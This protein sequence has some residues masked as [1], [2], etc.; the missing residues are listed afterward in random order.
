[1]VEASLYEHLFPLTT[2]M[3]QRVVEH[4]DGDIL[5]ADRWTLSQISG[6]GGTVAMN[7]AV[8]GGVRV[9]SGATNG[10]SSEIDFCNIRQYCDCASVFITVFKL[11]GTVSQQLQGG[12]F[13]DVAGGTSFSIV[14]TD[15]F[16]DACCFNMF[17]F[18]GTC[19]S[20]QSSCVAL[21]TSAHSHKVALNMCNNEWTIDGGC[22]CVTKTTNLPTT[23]LQPG[24][25]TRARSAGAKSIDLIYYE[26][27]NT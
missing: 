16:N 9:S 13:G 27:Y 21:D 25:F 23:K 12:L 8:N 4:F 11:V 10:N 15:T 19:S 18:D 2:V 6:C 14:G 1:M 5:C 17:T 7:D 24:M 26:A 20:Y 3:K 22:V